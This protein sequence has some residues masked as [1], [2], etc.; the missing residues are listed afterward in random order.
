MF[1]ILKL[2]TL[3]NIEQQIN[4]ILNIFNFPDF[5]LKNF[6]KNFG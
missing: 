5:E 3:L 4:K 6:V 1:V 2:I